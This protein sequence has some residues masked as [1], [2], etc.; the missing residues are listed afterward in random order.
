MVSFVAFAVF[1]VFP[2]LYP[3]CFSPS[4]LL[5]FAFLGNFCGLQPLLSPFT[6]SIAPSALFCVTLLVAPHSFHPA[7]QSRA[8]SF[9]APFYL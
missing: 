4:Y 6:F 2:S 8:L 3:S 5:F 9:K 7:V 1:V